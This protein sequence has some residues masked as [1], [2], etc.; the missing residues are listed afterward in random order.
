MGPFFS[1]GGGGNGAGG[2]LRLPFTKGD[3]EITASPQDKH[4]SWIFFFF[5]EKKKG[6]GL[7]GEGVKNAEGGCRKKSQRTL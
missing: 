5:Q 6:S 2:K 1:G 4:L 7:V 3:K